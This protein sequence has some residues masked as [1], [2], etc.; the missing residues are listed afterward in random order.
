MGPDSRKNHNEISLLPVVPASKLPLPV[1]CPRPGAAGFNGEQMV[2]AIPPCDLGLEQMV[3]GSM[4][5]GDG[6]E[7]IGYQE[8]EVK[9]FHGALYSGIFGVIRT[10]VARGAPI[11]LVTVKA[12]CEVSESMSWAKDITEQ[13]MEAM[14]VVSSSVN[15]EHHIELLKKMTFRRTALENSMRLKAAALDPAMAVSEL[16][17]IAQE[18]LTN[19]VQGHVG[20]GFQ[21]I[22]DTMKEVLDELEQGVNPERV[23]TGYQ[24]LDFLEGIFR[25]GSYNILAGLPGTG[26][27]SFCL[28]ITLNM[29]KKGL[30]V[31]LVSL[32][33]SATNTARRFV[34][35]MAEEALHY[36]GLKTEVLCDAALSFGG[37]PLYIESRIQTFDDLAANCRLLHAQH[38]PKLYIVDYLQLILSE[39]GED[40]VQRIS[41]VSRGLRQLSKQLNTCFIVTSQFNRDGAKSRDRPRIHHLKGSSQIEQDA[42]SIIIMHRSEAQHE[43]WVR[44]V[45]VDFYVD[46]NKNGPQKQF[47]LEFQMDIY[48]FESTPAKS[49]WR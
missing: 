38:S 30:P 23:E 35:L 6:G 5:L 43:D 20:Q 48:K 12:E 33:D 7:Q 8:L 16:N 9:D 39:S 15:I 19:I 42:D 3:I 2:D 17:G 1:D 37:F 47:S 28:N 27:T 36:D 11:D 40:D 49:Q 25:P 13:L 41:R 10:L 18:Y 46:K 21:P 32:D 22:V 26:K 14:N 4:L 24:E 31:A 44:R 29:L 45:P 34:S